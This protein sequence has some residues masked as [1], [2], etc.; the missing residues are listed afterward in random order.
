MSKYIKNDIDIQL[1][2]YITSEQKE[3]FRLFEKNRLVKLAANKKDKKLV[4]T[5]LSII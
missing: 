5:E 3:I 2:Q 1:S 4:L